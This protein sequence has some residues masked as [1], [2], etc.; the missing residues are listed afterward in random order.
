M[1]LKEPTVDWICAREAD[2]E[3][4]RELHPPVDQLGTRDVGHPHV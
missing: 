3:E 4:K 1:W 2:R